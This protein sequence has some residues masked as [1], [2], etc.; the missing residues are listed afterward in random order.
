MKTCLT[1]LLSMLFYVGFAQ[2]SLYFKSNH[3]KNYKVDCNQFD[4]PRIGDI[5]YKTW[6]VCP[7]YFGGSV[8]G[9]CD[10]QFYNNGSWSSYSQLQTLIFQ[11]FTGKRSQGSA[12]IFL[13]PDNALYLGH[14][15]WGFQLSDGQY[16]G[17]STE[18]YLK[19]IIRTLN[20]W[21]GEDNDM[22]G[23]MFRLESDMF[24]KMKQLGYDRYKRVTVNNP[25]IAGAKRRAEETMMKGF[26]AGNNCLDHTYHVL[27]G[28]GVPDMP[29]KQTNMAPNGWFNAFKHHDFRWL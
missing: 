22:W 4:D 29:W 28:Y 10:K 6:G 8:V 7:M 12:Y 17:G 13:K 5:F 15:G 23:E 1:A 19:G 3:K 21:P 20:R 26:G 25:N 18:N 27:E 16:F 2:Q 9:Y 11:K 24:A 14:I